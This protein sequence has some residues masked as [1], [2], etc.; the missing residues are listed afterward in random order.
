MTHPDP[1]GQ[2]MVQ[3]DTADASSPRSHPGSGV[4]AMEGWVKRYEITAAPS[5]SDQAL[6]YKLVMA[7][8]HAQE[9]LFWHDGMG[10]E[11]DGHK[12]ENTIADAL[13]SASRHE[14]RR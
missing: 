9:A 6:I 10:F 5:N 12:I 8:A 4:R 13:A 11:I 14:A 1:V 3:R 2:K 7:L